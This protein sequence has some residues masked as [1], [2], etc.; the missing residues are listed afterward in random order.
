MLA[1][2]VALHKQLAAE[3]PALRKRYRAAASHL[4]DRTGWKRV[5]EA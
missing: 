3:F 5:F 1:R 2:S 4:T